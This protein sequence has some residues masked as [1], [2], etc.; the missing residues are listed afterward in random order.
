MVP[1]R[2][3]AARAEQRV[4]SRQL[5]HPEPAHR[6]PVIP[7]HDD[8]PVALSKS[9]AA[10]GS[11]TAHVVGD[12]GRECRVSA[13]GLSKRIAIQPRI[14]PLLRQRAHQ[15]HSPAAPRHATLVRHR[16][17]CGLRVQLALQPSL[18]FSSVEAS[19]QNRASGDIEPCFLQSM[20]TNVANGVTEYDPDAAWHRAD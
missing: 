8:E 20:R 3:E 6:L 17:A 15:G 5:P 19:F 16:P 9:P 14:Q 12:D 2:R 11:S 7:G 18:C 10:P 1:A 4:P 13:R